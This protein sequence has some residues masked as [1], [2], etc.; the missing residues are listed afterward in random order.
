[1]PL[2]STVRDRSHLSQ[3]LKEFVKRKHF[4][5]CHFCPLSETGATWTIN[6]KN[7]SKGNILINAT[8]VHYQRQEPPEPITENE[9]P[10]ILSICYF[11]ISTLEY[12][13]TL[14]FK[15]V[16]SCRHQSIGQWSWKYVDI[17][18][19]LKCY[20]DLLRNVPS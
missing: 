7:L 3:Q 5:E 10:C 17:S 19:Y 11:V 2:L 4:N 9:S 12:Q 14:I 13:W 15:M 6:W 20:P 1:M 16:M 18:K 8:I